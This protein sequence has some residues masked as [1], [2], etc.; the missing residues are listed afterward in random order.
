MAALICILRGLPKDARVASFRF[1]KS[2]SQWYR[3]SKKNFV[4]TAVHAYWSLP[5]T[6]KGF[7]VTIP[8]ALVSFSVFSIFWQQ[9]PLRQLV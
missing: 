6:M 1:L 4:W 8:S 2:T 3:N 9:M 5:P 7:C